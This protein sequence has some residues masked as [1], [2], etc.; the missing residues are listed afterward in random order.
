MKETVLITGGTGL[1]GQA[2]TETLVK[3]GYQ[4]IILTRKIPDGNYPGNAISYAKWDIRRQEVDTVAI[5]RADH[6]I[7]LAG[8]GVVDKRWT[9]SYKK[10]ILDSRTQSSSLLISSL[11]KNPHKVK[12]IVSASAIG[13]Y[14]PDPSP[15]PGGFRE[16]DPAADYFLGNT[17]KLWEQSVDPAEGLGIRLIKF[18]IG[19]VLSNKGGALA[20]FRKPLRMGVAAILGNGK[21]IV[22]WVHIS[23]LCSMFL[24]AIRNPQF[25]GVYN[26]VA[27]APVSNGTLTKTLAR[28]LNG[29][30]FIPLHV[31]GFVLKMVMG[32]SSIEVLKSTT[33]QPER[34][35]DAGFRFQFADI[36]SA[37]EE[38]CR[39]E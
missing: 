11:Q 29:R 7:H 5:S 28:K 34:L 1:V 12:T 39:R 4:V 3:A 38:L 27:P 21:Q 17:C 8:A 31:P 36:D 24:E 25:S 19:I 20:E 10:E 37:L 2:I 13:Y 22:S 26:A 14:G 6:I 15:H 30:W 9:E 16:T 35:L 23:D 32:G 33:I 18:R